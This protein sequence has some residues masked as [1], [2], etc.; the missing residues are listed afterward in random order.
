M[1]RIAFVVA[2][3]FGAAYAQNAKNF[4]M[5]LKFGY[6]YTGF[7]DNNVY[8]KNNHRPLFGL[9]F[10]VRVKDWFSVA[11]EINLTPKGGTRRADF[12]V[13]P[14]GQYN[15]RPYSENRMVPVP[16]GAKEQ[17]FTL[18]DRLDLIYVQVP[19]LARFMFLQNVKIYVNTGP[20]LNVLVLPYRW[21][22]EI[23]SDPYNPA[24]MKRAVE[25]G[26]SDDRSKYN[27]VEFSWI[28]GA[29]LAVPMNKEKS[30]WFYFEPVR[31]DLGVTRAIKK[32]L[33]VGGSQTGTFQVQLGF[34]F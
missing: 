29:G 32:E 8:D 3:G 21:Y 27:P 4:N 12:G 10:N 31:Y 11:P 15:P 13:K 34:G 9:L 1:K 19:V 33:T 18:A 25:K 16:A 17:K 28:F 14:G 22:D 24:D 7:F 23:Y 5:G 20:S 26:D 2:L 30:S 6:N